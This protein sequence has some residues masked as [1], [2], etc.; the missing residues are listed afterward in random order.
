MDSSSVVTV[1]G[2]PFGGVARL[3]REMR[4]WQKLQL[5]LDECENTGGSA[6][7]AILS[8]VREHERWFVI[9]FRTDSVV[10]DILSAAKKS[11]VS[12]KWV[13]PHSLTLHADGSIE[14]VGYRRK[15]LTDCYTS[16]EWTVWHVLTVH[17]SGEV[18]YTMRT[19]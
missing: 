6:Y 9:T 7:I 5:Q 3:I 10:G 14:F 1:I 11:Q 4:R 18:S 8:R 19:E 13:T 15:G 12:E 16:M 17:P 2:I